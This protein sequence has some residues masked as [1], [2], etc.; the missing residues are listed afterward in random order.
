MIRVYQGL[1]YSNSGNCDLLKFNTD[2]DGS[3]EFPRI[4]KLGG[5]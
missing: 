2:Y 1:S 4:E 5:G 3:V